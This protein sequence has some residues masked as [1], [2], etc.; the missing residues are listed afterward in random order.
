ML[1]HITF[2]AIVCAITCLM[3]FNL[4]AGFVNIYL[5]HFKNY[6]LLLK[7]FPWGNFHNHVSNI[8]KQI[9]ILKNNKKIYKNLLKL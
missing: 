3:Q 9:K 2:M 1:E 8:A 5:L 7:P 6:I 4:K